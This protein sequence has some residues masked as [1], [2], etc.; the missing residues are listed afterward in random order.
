[1]I[2]LAIVAIAMGSIY[3]M[4]SQTIFM[5]SRSRFNLI[6]PILASSKLSEIEISD[7]EIPTEDS[8]SFEDGYAG[9]S[10]RFQV[11]DVESD[12]YN[13]NGPV[14]KKLFISIST[15]NDEETFLMTTYR[16]IYE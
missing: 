2:A 11:E 1:M 10:W 6:A 13:S 14:I 9:Y 16:C 12:L 15:E 7:N 5:E 8:G 4:H 3:K